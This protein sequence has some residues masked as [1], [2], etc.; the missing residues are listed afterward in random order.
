MNPST[1]S[2]RSCSNCPAGIANEVVSQFCMVGYPIPHSESE[3]FYAV[4]VP[5]RVQ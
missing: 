2:F 1:S 4:W 3:R 5:P